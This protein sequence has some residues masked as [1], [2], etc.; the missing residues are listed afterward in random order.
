MKKIL[1]VAMLGLTI[2]MAG[3]GCG[4]EANDVGKGT[5]VSVSAETE[6]AVVEE[7]IVAVKELDTEIPESETSGTEISGG[8][9]EIEA[10]VETEE[11][12]EESDFKVTEM[13]AVKYAKSSVNVRKGPS[14]DYEK[15]GM[16]STN[17]EV[18]V[19][20][21]ADTGWYQ[22]ELD[23][24]VAYVSNNYLVDE[25]VVVNAN[26]ETTDN[27]ITENIGSDA[28]GSGSGGTGATSEPTT[29]GES[30]EEDIWG[31]DWDDAETVGGIGTGTPAT[32]G[33]GDGT[34]IEISP[35]P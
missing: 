17:Q 25:K 2:T 9:K 6:S 34:V 13:S 18:V 16:L 4:A 15:I 10:P 33:E 30:S 21:Q 3:C 27:E 12:E 19:T 22:I 8:I 29:G 24:E 28:G 35:A 32:D 1:L 20:G 26:S 31:D 14:S 11:A 5:E 23:G 7:L